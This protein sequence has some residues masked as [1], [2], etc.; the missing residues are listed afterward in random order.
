MTLQQEELDKYLSTTVEVNE[1]L[2]P[3]QSWISNEQTYPLIAPLA[4]DLLSIPASSAPVERTF[5]TVGEVA[6]GKKN[7]LSDKS[8]VREVIKK[9]KCY[10]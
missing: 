3:I 5:S 7:R 2:D 9:N 4:C 10:L 6:S 8:L 1:R